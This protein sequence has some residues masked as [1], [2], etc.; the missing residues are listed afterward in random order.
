MQ[1]GSWML[2]GQAGITRSMLEESRSSSLGST[3]YD[4]HRGA[5]F[6]LQPGV[7]YFL[8]ENW[9]LGLS[10]NFQIVNGK[11]LDRN[12][13]VIA[14]GNYR[15]YGLG[16]FTRRYSPVSDKL[17]FYGDIRVGGYLG[18]SGTIDLDTSER[19]VHSKRKGIDASASVGLQYLVADFLGVNLQSTL[20]A[21]DFYKLTGVSYENTQRRSEL[22]GGL[23]SSFQIGASFF[24]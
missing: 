20:I 14:K 10:G 4:Q 13:E 7:G 5:N 15:G 17:A 18:N 22:N 9:A 23:F 6:Y 16:V 2:D 11:S 8:K 3:G 24:F 1:K 21:Y 19:T 12:D